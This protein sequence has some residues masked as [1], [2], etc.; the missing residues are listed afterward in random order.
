[1]RSQWG[2][3]RIEGEIDI[4]TK[5]PTFSDM[6]SV[7]KEDRPYRTR[8]NVNVAFGIMDNYAMENIDLDMIKVIDKYKPEIQRIVDECKKRAKRMSDE[9]VAYDYSQGFAE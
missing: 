6:I 8:L 3:R 2:Y 1:M 9:S 5:I 4:G 7:L